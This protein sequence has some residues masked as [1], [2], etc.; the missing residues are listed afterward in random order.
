MDCKCK[1]VNRLCYEVMWCVCVCDCVVPKLSW[2]KLLKSIVKMVTKTYILI[3]V[4]L[5]LY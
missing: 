5:K 2:L 3:C 4:V 1:C